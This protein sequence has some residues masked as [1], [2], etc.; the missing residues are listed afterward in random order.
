MLLATKG[1]PSSVIPSKCGTTYW[2]MRIICYHLEL[3][4]L[5]SGLHQII[6]KTYPQCL[7]LLQKNLLR[8]SMLIFQM[9]SKVCFILLILHSLNLKPYTLLLQKAS[10]AMEA[11]MY[12]LVLRFPFDSLLEK[13][14]YCS[15]FQGMILTAWIFFSVVFILSY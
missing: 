7:H 10:L 13:E 1:V 15:S 14:Q 4:Q 5:F 12:F 3:E 11:E 2:M 8:N 9:N 6:Y